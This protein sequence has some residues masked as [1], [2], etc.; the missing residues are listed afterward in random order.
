VQA[1]DKPKSTMKR[2]KYYFYFLTIFL[3]VACGQNESKKTD[4]K[5]SAI[6]QVDTLQIKSDTIHWLT[7]NQFTPITFINA[8]TKSNKQDTLIN[9]ITMVDEFPKDWIKPSDIDTLMTLIRSTKKCNCFLNPLSSFI[10]TKDHADIGGYAIIF[11]NAYRQKTKVDLGLYSCPKTDKKSV[12]EITKWW[13][14]T[15]HKK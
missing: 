13:T 5:L 10:P 12:D 6:K 9:V 7:P 4:D 1:S 15:K 11:I 8:V 2:L 3:L 14:E